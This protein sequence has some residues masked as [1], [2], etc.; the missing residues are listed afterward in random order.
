MHD[1]NGHPLNVGDTVVILAKITQI[2]ATP[3][4]CNVSLETTYGRRPDGA[5]ERISSINT[6]V[7]VFVENNEDQIQFNKGVT[8]L[9]ETKA[10]EEKKAAQ[11]AWFEGYKQRALAG[12]LTDMDRK[13]KLELVHRHVIPPIPDEDLEPNHPANKG[14]KKAKT[15][16][17]KKDAPTK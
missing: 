7:M 13:V 5:K 1:K 9:D 2:S 16:E 11:L 15:E 10:I 8:A 14:K 3:D 12:K 4:F 6:G 17:A